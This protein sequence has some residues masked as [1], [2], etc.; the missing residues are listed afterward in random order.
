MAAW[1]CVPSEAARRATIIIR[2][3]ETDAAGSARLGQL[4]RYS[5]GCCRGASVGGTRSKEERRTRLREG[6]WSA[7]P[8]ERGE[9][10]FAMFLRGCPAVF[11][12]TGNGRPAHSLWTPNRQDTPSGSPL[13]K[14]GPFCNGRGPPP[15]T[16][17]GEG[18]PC[19]GPLHLTLESLRGVRRVKK[20][21]FDDRCTVHSRT[22][23]GHGRT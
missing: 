13:S 6:V 11:D 18:P 21:T 23:T 2:G 9:C 22:D 8:W 7:V 20:G 10:G 17:P 14:F 5:G 15:G 1:C 3:E 19:P 12:V 16:P 4:L